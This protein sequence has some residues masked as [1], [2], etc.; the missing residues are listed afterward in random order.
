MLRRAQ[1]LG[2]SRE[3]LGRIIGV[4]AVVAIGLGPLYLDTFYVGLFAL[5]I[6]YGLFAFGLDLAWG[7]AGV[8]SIG[9]AVFFGLGAYGV[10]IAQTRG[11]SSLLGAVAGVAAAAALAAVIGAIGLR[12][13]AN[14]STMAV[15]TL[16][17]TLLASKAAIAWTSVTGGSNGLFV[18]PPDSMSGY[19]WVCFAASAA[20]VGAVWAGILRRPLGNRWLAIRLNERRAEHLGMPVYRSQVIAFALGGVISAVAGALAAP[21]LST[22]SAEQVGILLSTQVLVW[23]AIGGRATLLGPFIGA[24]AATYG[25]DALAGTLGDVYLLL[26]GIAF[27]GVVLFL[28]QG[29]AGLLRAGRQAADTTPKAASAGR[30]PAIATASRDVLV[31]DRIVKRFEGAVAVD[32]PT[33]RV[34]DREVVCLIGPN[35][36]GKTTLLNVISGALS[37]ESGVITLGATELTGTPPFRRVVAGLGRTF[38]VPSLFPGL[39]VAEHLILARQQGRAITELPAA[40]RELEDAHGHTPA[41]ALSMS[42]RRSLEIA[43]TLCL[44]PRVLLLDEPA[45]GLAHQETRS[46]ARSLLSI[47]DTLGCSIVAVEHDM[48]IVRELADRVVCLHQGQVIADG[49][50][51]EVSADAGVRS[52]YLGAA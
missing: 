7:R 4:A 13:A 43:M 33:L 32:G 38:Q 5:G 50:M 6:V 49:T 30:A 52:A 37:P 16:A 42:D 46:L 48:D 8:V 1:A 29:A 31:A 22:V 11:T 36:A 47:R 39:T 10:A 3:A 14:P 21:L 9:H 35:G 12:R 17:T 28:P 25:E 41:E 2:A 18:L 15:L 20:I 34:A 26:L 19:Y 24:I 23:L 27:V 40:Y 51:D 45:A 44:R